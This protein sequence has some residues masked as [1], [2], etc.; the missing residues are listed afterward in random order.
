MHLGYLKIL[1]DFLRLLFVYYF[2]MAMSEVNDQFTQNIKLYTEF[3]FA[4]FIEKKNLY[5]T[6]NIY[7]IFPFAEAVLGEHQ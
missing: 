2:T 5:K 1:A 7:I 6:N 3:S 4:Y